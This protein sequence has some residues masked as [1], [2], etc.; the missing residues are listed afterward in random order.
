MRNVRNGKSGPAHSTHYS[1][2]WYRELPPIQ[3][4]RTLGLRT[5]TAYSL[6]HTR[7]LGVQ[8]LTDYR[9]L[10]L[11]TA[12]SDPV[13]CD[14]VRPGPMRPGQTRSHATRSD[15]VPC[16]PVRSTGSDRGAK[17]GLSRHAW[18]EPGVTRTD[19]SKRPRP[20]HPPLPS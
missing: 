1:L 6:Q 9:S 13:P 12:R 19:P 10:S 16:D 2:S 4:S 3:H 8:T 17:V 18:R 15:P 11:H 5:L 20:G 14:P 7:T